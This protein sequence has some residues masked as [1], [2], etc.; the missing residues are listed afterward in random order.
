MAKVYLE[1][2]TLTA[3]GSAIRD[4]A[5]TSNLLLPSEMPSAISAIQAG[6]GGSEIKW[7]MATI[8]PATNAKVIDISPWITDANVNDWFM[9]G[10]FGYWNMSDVTTTMCGTQLIGPVLRDLTPTK[11]TKTDNI[12]QAR[13]ASDA[14]QPHK[15]DNSLANTYLFWNTWRP[16]TWDATAKTLTWTNATYLGKK[17]VILVYR[18]V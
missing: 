12:G 6:G 5:G 11:G 8:T 9:Y 17:T 14:S 7:K 16:Y 18:E 4:K 15:Y 3:I 2:T 1:D 13:I 10:S